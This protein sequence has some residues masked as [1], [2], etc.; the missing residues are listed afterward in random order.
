MGTV[1]KMWAGF[2]VSTITAVFAIA[3]YFLGGECVGEGA[4]QVCSVAGFSST[5]VI[6]IVSM[7]LGNAAVTGVA[8][9]KVPNKEQTFKS[10]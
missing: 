7:L 3:A 10:G 2:G 8:V 1:A 9:Y 4:A 6:T 5:Q